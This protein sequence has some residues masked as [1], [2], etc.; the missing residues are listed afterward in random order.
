MVFLFIAIF[1]IIILFCFPFRVGINLF[2]SKNSKKVNF[3]Y[4]FFNS[5]KYLEKKKKNDSK[6]QIIKQVKKRKF[7]V[8]IKKE[9]LKYIAMII[10]E[11]IFLEGSV[12]TCDAAL[13]YPIS[14][15]VI[16]INSLI[17]YG[18]YGDAFHLSL[19]AGEEDYFQLRIFVKLNLHIIFSL[20]FQIIKIEY[21]RK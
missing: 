15:A 11:N 1:G 16:F 17:R 2:A 3:S 4:V 10:P 8:K 18:G 21:R 20:F 12:K 14:A 6:K 5:V 13:F 7:N 9:N 19:T